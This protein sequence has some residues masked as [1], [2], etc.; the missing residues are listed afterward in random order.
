MKL[1]ASDLKLLNMHVIRME[2]TVSSHL[3]PYHFV[4]KAIPFRTQVI[5]IVFDIKS[6]V[7]TNKA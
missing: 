7:S 6:C 2:L 4:P 3:V 5:I 1:E